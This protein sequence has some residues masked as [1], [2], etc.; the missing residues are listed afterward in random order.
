MAELT[1]ITPLRAFREG[2]GLDLSRDVRPFVCS[3][4]P[5]DC[6]TF[7]VGLNAATS[8]GQPFSNYWNDVIGFDRTK[9]DTD[10]FC[11]RKET[12]RAGTGNRRVI[13]AISRHIQPCLETNIYPTPTR[14]ARDLT[15]AM[16]RPILPYLLETIR[17]EL[18]FV[19]SKPALQF[20]SDLT[21]RK[22]ITIEPRR[23]RV[24]GHEFWLSGR[25]GPLYTLSSTA[26]GE[27]GQMLAEHLG[28]RQQA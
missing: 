28:T 12:R 18:I 13:A 11:A 21:G 7:I 26:A 5:L 8:L 9:F 6:R 19:H 14:R 24:N 17:P 23:V 4:S 3:G 22:T 10:Y 16:R 20:L 1:G 2:L 15:P 25:P 27:I